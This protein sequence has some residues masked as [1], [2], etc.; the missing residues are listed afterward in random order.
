MINPYFIYVL[1]FLAVLIAYL[2]GWSNLFPN[3]GG[4]LLIFLLCSIIIALF[5]GR[6]VAK[7][8]IITFNRL[9]YKDKLVWVTIAI[10]VG[11]V[12]EFIYH[13][14]FPLLAIITNIPLSYH[15]FGIPTFHV[16]LVTFN[17]FFSIVLFQVLLSE[18]KKRKG[19]LILLLVLNLLPSVLI[20]NRGMLVIILMSCVFVYLIR[21]QDK[22]TM[23]KVA[24]LL[25]LFLIALYLF[26]VVGNVRVNNSYQTD[27]S[28]FDNS[29]FLQLGGASEEFRESFIPKEYFWPYIY[30]TSPMANL[31][32]TLNNFEHNEDVTTYNTF[33]F[34]VTQIFPDFVSKR[35]AAML[36]ISVP[37]VLQIAPEFNVGTAFAESFVILGWVG[38]S[39]FVLFLFVFALFYILFLKSINSKY[40]VAGV[41]IINS[42]FVFN[43]FTNMFAFTGL[44]FQLVYPILFTIWDTFRNKKEGRCE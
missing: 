35:I 42:I 27:T 29:L 17:S 25:G 16:I 33:S 10:L 24:G 37:N 12:I 6:E 23:K 34:V 8:K 21:Y 40:F 15:E 28:L 2:F 3:L 38:I 5:M 11:Y 14:N 19:K 39:L 7:R 13:G 9:F 4:S 26:G 22:I 41:A 44:S 18:E 31:Q 1:S 20:M 36:S 30:L 32:E 43:A